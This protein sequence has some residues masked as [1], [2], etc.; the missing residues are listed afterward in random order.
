MATDPKKD[1]KTLQQHLIDLGVSRSDELLAKVRFEQSLPSVAR[2]VVSGRPA[3]FPLSVTIE[4]STALGTI[5]V[6]PLAPATVREWTDSMW[7]A[8]DKN[9]DATRKAIEMLEEQLSR[10]ELSVASARQQEKTKKARRKI[11][12]KVSERREAEAAAAKQRTEQ[13][14]SEIERWTRANAN[15]MKIARQEMADPVAR[16]RTLQRRFAR[17]QADTI[18][19]YFAVPEAAQ[20]KALTDTVTF[21]LAARRFEHGQER[22]VQRRL[23]E[24]KNG[25]L[26][27]NDAPVCEKC[28]VPMRLRYGKGGA[29][30]GCP[31]YPVC[32]E[33][34]DARRQVA[35]ARTRETIRETTEGQ[36]GV[37]WPTR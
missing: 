20:D 15:A 13:S 5:R 24:I 17:P 16:E 27:A 11:A 37:P 6:F 36:E 33:V 29:F 25:A 35:E 34:K 9:P 18:R 12:V 3:Q 31:A 10:A 4:A 2:C 28:G 23:L 22:Y 7:I 32:R 26:L 14:L 19:L 1:K 8:G 30:W 21:A